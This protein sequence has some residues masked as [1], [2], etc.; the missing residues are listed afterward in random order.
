MCV[1]VFVCLSINLRECICLCVWLFCF[2]VDLSVNMHI[3]VCVSVFV[4]ACKTIHLCVCIYVGMIVSIA[5]DYS[6]IKTLCW[7]NTISIMQLLGP[8]SSMIPRALNGMRWSISYYALCK[9]AKAIKAVITKTLLVTD[10]EYHDSCIKFVLGPSGPQVHQGGK[11]Q[12]YPPLVCV[13]SGRNLR[14]VSISGP[15]GA[16]NTGEAEEKWDGVICNLSSEGITEQQEV[17]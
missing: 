12:R 5:R 10:W 8:K 4:S 11:R 2:I 9:L 15:R 17:K 6:K 3:C 13:M 7:H 1:W 14:L 16:A